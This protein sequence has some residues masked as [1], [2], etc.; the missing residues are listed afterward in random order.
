LIMIAPLV[1]QPPGPGAVNY[2]WEPA[3]GSA[4]KISGIAFAPLQ[5]FGTCNSELGDPMSVALY[6]FCVAMFGPLLSTLWL[7]GRAR[8]DGFTPQTGWHLLFAT[9]T[10]ALY[11]VLFPII[12]FASLHLFG[13]STTALGHGTLRQLQIVTVST[14][15][16]GLVVAGGAALPLRSGRRL[17]GRRWLVAGLGLV[18]A[19]ASA[20]VLEFLSY[21]SPKPSYGALL[22][23][24]IGLLALAVVERCAVCTTVAVAFTVAALAANVTG[25]RGA[26]RWLGIGHGQW[27]SLATAFADLT[28]PGAILL[29][30]AVV[31]ACAA[32]GRRV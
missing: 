2:V 19:I 14:F 16:T 11:V 23:I 32:A 22:I 17:T 26:A 6:W 21:L 8:R 7:R 20:A 29:L 27:S 30:G 13:D 28:V 15:V 5:Q 25:F 4:P 9:T 24:A 18:L 1:Y 3:I 10:L 31:G 12:E